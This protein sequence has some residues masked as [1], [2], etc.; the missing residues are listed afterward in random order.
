M[1]FQLLVL[2]LMSVMKIYHYK[3]THFEFKNLLV[4]IT[5]KKKKIQKINF[6]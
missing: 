6:T 1:H 3:T 5:Y 4:I 2:K